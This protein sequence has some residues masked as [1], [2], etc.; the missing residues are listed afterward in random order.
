MIVLQ[1]LSEPKNT[2]EIMNSN[3]FV[4]IETLTYALGNIGGDS[5]ITIQAKV[6]HHLACVELTIE[7]LHLHRKSYEL[8]IRY[9]PHLIGERLTLKYF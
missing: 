5:L 4:K 8:D 3:D 6:L 7:K 1:E 9:L 2:D